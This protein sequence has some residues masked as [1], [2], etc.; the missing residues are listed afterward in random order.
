MNFKMLVG[1]IGV[2]VGCY[3]LG[4]GAGFIIPGSEWPVFLVLA[5][6]M[7]VGLVLAVKQGRFNT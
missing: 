4:Q 3:A 7:T 6:L 2:Y 5:A 1:T